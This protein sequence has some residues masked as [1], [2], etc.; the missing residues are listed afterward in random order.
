[1]QVEQLEIR[2]TSSPKASKE[3]PAKAAD[4]SYTATRPAPATVA[5]GK[6]WA[7]IMAPSKRNPYEDVEF[8]PISIKGYS[9][10]KT[11][12][13][14]LMSVANVAIHPTKPIL[15][16]VSDDKTW[17]MWHMPAGDLIMCGEGHKDWV[18]GV[19]FHPAGTALATGSG[20]NTVKIWDFEKQKCA[21][22]FTDHK[23]VR[24]RR[25]LQPEVS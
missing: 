17:K 3:S 22:T 4:A 7:S 23:Q 15:V 20:D 9:L 14:H 6:G 5:K 2:A 24:G 19:D 12:K 11:F 16:T 10:Q 25:V 18:A 1:M 13:G 21:L 8:E